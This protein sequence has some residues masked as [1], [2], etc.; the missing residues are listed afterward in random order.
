MPAAAPAQRPQLVP[1]T[2]NT[3]A[4]IIR[5]AARRGEHMTH[6]IAGGLILFNNMPAGPEQNAVADVAARLRATYP[7]MQLHG[8]L[9]AAHLIRT[10]DK[11]LFDSLAK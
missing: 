10:S 2:E 9:G 11:Q 7:D 8:S 3:R 1:N 5:E 4:S 6:A